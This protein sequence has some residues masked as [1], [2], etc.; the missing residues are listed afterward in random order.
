MLTSTKSNKIQVDMKNTAEYFVD[1]ACKF[2]KGSLSRKTLSLLEV[3][4]Y[5]Y[6]RDMEHAVTLVVN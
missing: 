3:N 1:L 4:T 6:P 5:V 2:K